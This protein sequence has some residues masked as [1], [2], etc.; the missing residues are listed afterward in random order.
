MGIFIRCR[1]WAF[2]GFSS[3]KRVN[4]H[5]VERICERLVCI[6]RCRWWIIAKICKKKM[7]WTEI[8]LAK[9]ASS[10]RRAVDLWN[11]NYYFFH[12]EAKNI[13]SSE[14][15][16]VWLLKSNAMF[17]YRTTSAESMSLFSKDSWIK[18]QKSVG[19]NTEHL[20]S[21][22]T[23][24]YKNFCFRT[25]LLP[26]SH[27]SVF[28]WRLNYSTCCRQLFELKGQPTNFLSFSTFWTF[29]FSFFEAY[30]FKLSKLF[31]NIIKL[32][33][34]TFLSFFSLESFE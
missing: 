28:N 3:M 25:P 24:P 16:A 22:Q 5:L 17:S 8:F 13:F 10:A 4:K 9:K 27:L 21:A 15:K 32:S 2:D 29:F 33:V 23:K 12:L 1:V 18:Q 11:F 26:K 6:Y 19:W 20:K 31:L 30:F 14:N 34:L 7:I